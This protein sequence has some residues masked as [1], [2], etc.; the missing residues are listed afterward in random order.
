MTKELSHQEQRI[1][2]IAYAPN[3]RG[4]EYLKQKLAERKGEIDNP[5][6]YLASV[7]LLSEHLIEMLDIKS[8]IWK[9]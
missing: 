2:L 7:T 9:N 5:Q 1:I 6:L 4:S 8:G 3:N